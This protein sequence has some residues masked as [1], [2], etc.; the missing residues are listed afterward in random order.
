MGFHWAFREFIPLVIFCVV[1]INFGDTLNFI[2][3]TRARPVLIDYIIGSRIERK[4]MVF[5]KWNS[6]CVL[7]SASSAFGMY[8]VVHKS[9]FFYYT[10]LNPLHH[11]HHHQLH[12]KSL[13]DLRIVWAYLKSDSWSSRQLYEHLDRTRLHLEHPPTSSTNGKPP[14]HHPF[15][16]LK[17]KPNPIILLT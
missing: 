11:E 16:Y 7:E 12:Q 3:L 14:K 5:H 6:T 17:P 13:L 10:R 2:I 15:S 1:H 8:C 9:K 4:F